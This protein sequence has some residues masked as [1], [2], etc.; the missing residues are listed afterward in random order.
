[1]DLLQRKVLEVH[2]DLGRVFFRKRL[3]EDLGF[4]FAESALKIAVDN[5]YDWRSGSSKARLKIGRDLAKISLERACCHV[6]YV[7]LNDALS[8]GRHI[9]S[10]G[11]ARLPH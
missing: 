7:A 6:E 2:P 8:V 9:E 5:Q 4:L 1:M 10:H 3:A 11:L